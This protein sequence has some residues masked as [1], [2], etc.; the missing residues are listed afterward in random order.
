MRPG[1]LRADGEGERLR[2]LVRA[3]DQKKGLKSR[4][5]SRLVVTRGGGDERKL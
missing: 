2:R 1:R 4:R 5:I 3:R